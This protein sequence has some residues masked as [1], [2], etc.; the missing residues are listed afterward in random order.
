MESTLRFTPAPRLAWLLAVLGLL[1]AALLVAI[2]IGSQQPVRLENGTI[3]YGSNDGDIFVL[4]PATGKSTPLISTPGRDATPTFSRD[5]SM[6]VYWRDAASP[7][8]YELAITNVDGTIVRALTHPRAPTSIVWSPDG[9]RLL[10]VDSSPD[11]L[12]IVSVDGNGTREIETGMRTEQ[13]FWRPD[14][15]QIVFQGLSSINGVQSFGIYVVNADGTGLRSILPPVTSEAHVQEPALSPDGTQ[16]AYGVWDGDDVEGGNL[17]V[18]DVD[19]GDTRIIQF[20][21]GDW[22]DY[23]PAWSPDGKQLVFTRGRPQESYHLAVGPAT[24]GDVANLGPEMPWDAGV[25]AAFSPD[26]SKVIA[27]YADRSIWIFDASG[28]P[29]TKLEIRVSGL[30]SWQGIEP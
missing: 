15:R 1:V 19:S 7:G 2:F 5:G 27:Q 13:A 21:G 30:P 18:T 4:D 11:T 22:E 6:F 12:S 3:I 20:G 14:G 26:G 23:F 29:G 24:G 25:I 9:A 10:V 17:Y 28:G 8:T 16:V